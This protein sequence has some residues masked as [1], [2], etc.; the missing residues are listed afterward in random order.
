MFKNSLSQV[1]SLYL[2][3]KINFIYSFLFIGAV[4]KRFV[5]FA[6]A[7]YRDHVEVYY[8]RKFVG[9]FQAN[10]RL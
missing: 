6:F 10:I 9:K 8:D 4:D 7:F 2:Y 3:Y 5:W 1:I